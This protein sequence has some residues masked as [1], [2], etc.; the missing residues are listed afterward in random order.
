MK[1]KQVERE[2][3]VEANTLEEVRARLKG[4]VPRGMELLSEQVLSNGYQRSSKGVAETMEAAFRQAQS[5]IPPGAEITAKREVASPAERTIAIE[6]FDEESAVAQAKR[7]VGDAAS[8][9]SAD[10]I[11]TGKKGFLGIGKKPNRYEVQISELAV[12]E[13][14]FKEKARIRAAIGKRPKCERCGRS[15][16]YLLPVQLMAADTGAR[17][18]DVDVCDK[19]FTDLASGAEQMR[20]E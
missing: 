8:V 11:A 1:E 7:E 12:A 17:S 18:K 2:I 16:D 9:G 3:E 14:T 6:A 20:F 10:L 4:H 5:N 19:C 15:A 13:V